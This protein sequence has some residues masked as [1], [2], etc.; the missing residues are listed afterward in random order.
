MSSD[1]VTY[2]SNK[3]IAVITINRPEKMNA[4]SNGVVASIRDAFIKLNESNLFRTNC[5]GIHCSCLEYSG[6]SAKLLANSR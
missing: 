6:S 1:L 3:G 5:H 4:L 2:E